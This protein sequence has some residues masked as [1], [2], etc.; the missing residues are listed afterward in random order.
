MGMQGNIGLSR[1]SSPVE[2]CKDK[3]NGQKKSFEHKNSFFSLFF[4]VTP[5]YDKT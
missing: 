3:Q 5:M 1:R 2:Q 4:S